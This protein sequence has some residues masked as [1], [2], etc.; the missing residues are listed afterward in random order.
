MA[1][2]KCEEC[3]KKV[4]DTC[5]TCPNCGADIQQQIYDSLS[6]EEKMAYD[7]EF[8]K[9]TR[10]ERWLNILLFMFLVF[11]TIGSL[12]RGMILL[13]VFFLIMTIIYGIHLFRS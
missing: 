11:V 4:S 5:E 1:L 6:D 3:G 8:R 7:A 2:I 13:F 10:P 12:V 9:Q